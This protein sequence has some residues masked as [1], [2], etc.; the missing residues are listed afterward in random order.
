[1][2]NF[3]HPPALDF[4]QTRADAPASMI[5]RYFGSNVAELLPAHGS[6]FGQSR[7]PQDGRLRQIGVVII[8]AAVFRREVRRIGALDA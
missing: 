4:V 2:I 3:V 7:C 5:E 8:A 6:Q 1:M